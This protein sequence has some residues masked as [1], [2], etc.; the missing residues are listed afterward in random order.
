MPKGVVCL[1]YVLV[2]KVLQMARGVTLA[3]VTK[4]RKHLSGPI[5]GNMPSKWQKI[6]I[7]SVTH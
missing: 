6:E 3:E 5:K 1:Y 2:L 4:Q 7:N